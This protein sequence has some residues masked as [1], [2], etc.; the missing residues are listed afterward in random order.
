MKGKNLVKI[1]GTPPNPKWLDTVERDSPLKDTHKVATI[2]DNNIGQW[3][4]F[5]PYP[6]GKKGEAGEG[7]LLRVDRDFW[8]GL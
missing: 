7:F 6:L 5:P 2:S 3:L 4:P 1:R 8:L